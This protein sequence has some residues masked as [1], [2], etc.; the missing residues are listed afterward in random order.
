VVPNRQEKAHFF[1][2]RNE[3]HELGPEFLYI[4]VTIAVRRVDFV[5]DR[6]LYIIL[7]GR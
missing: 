1:G 2:K 7:R 3:N 5:S 4:R 6:M